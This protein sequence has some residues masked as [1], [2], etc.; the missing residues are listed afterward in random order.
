MRFGYGVSA[1]RRAEDELMARLPPGTLM[2][3][4][5]AGLAAA[6]HELLGQQAYGRR[7]ALLVGAGDNGG[8]ALFAGARLARRG[9][10]VSAVLLDPAKA[11]PAGLAEL[12]AAGGTAEPAF[13]GQSGGADPT[14]SAASVG[15]IEAADLI[16][17]GIVGIGASGA[18]RSAPAA[19]VEVLGSASGAVL[20]VD[21]P[22]GIDP[23]TGAVPGAAVRAD[24]TVTFGA[25]K[26]G[27][28]VDPGASCA[29][30]VHL[31][32][33]GLGPYLPAEPALA[34]LQRSDVVAAWPAPR[35]P[36]LDKY[37]RGVIGVLAG[38]TA[39]PG[40]AVLA[41][42]GALRGGAG[43]VRYVGPDRVGALVHSYWPE[44]VVAADP[45]EAGRV[46]AWL[47]GPGLGTGSDADRRLDIVLAS[48]LPVL[49]DA[50]A[51]T[52]LARRGSLDRAAPT[53]LT[54]HAGEAARLLGHEDRAHVEAH[55]LAAVT[56]LAKRYRA[57]VLLKGTTT[58]VAPA[59]PAEQPVM[60][61]PTG[62]PWL[63]TAGSG[64]VLAG[65]AGALLAAGLGPV[66]AGSVGAYL[67]GLAARLA[68]E[69][70]V[71]ITASDV[72]AAL[73]LAW[74]DLLVA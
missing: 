40:A 11:H 13:T 3:R 7:V 49:L 17:D 52:L 33:I 22:S 31:V 23:D 18:L 66:Q 58:L 56:E 60:V 43:M 36:E 4:A 53:L 10:V 24:V 54:P 47:A 29:G 2:Q 69:S 55:R 68:A 28:L 51:L 38:S 44:A 1:I 70:G 42:G 8:D 19:L 71:P 15:I 30:V 6:G 20:A 32:D 9:A 63:A 27:L 21:L 50:D 46:Q 14:V 74:R 35:D 45:T 48:E 65:L 72:L 25:H 67:H 37:R 39:Y 57:T 61:N 5:A 26:V 73:P 34:A 16:L 62:T 12:V 64:D 41:V 59:G